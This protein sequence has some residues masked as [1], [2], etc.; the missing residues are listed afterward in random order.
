MKSD[1]DL[2]AVIAERYAANNPDAPELVE[3]HVVVRVK[4][5]EGG[6]ETGEFEDRIEAVWTRP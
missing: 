2:M 1:P 4:Q 5:L 6:K 3:L